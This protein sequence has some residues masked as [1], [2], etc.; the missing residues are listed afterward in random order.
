MKQEASDLRPIMMESMS[1]DLEQRLLLLYLL[2]TD[3]SP[4]FA[5]AIDARSIDI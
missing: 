1:L 2:N 4:Q 5:K 3:L